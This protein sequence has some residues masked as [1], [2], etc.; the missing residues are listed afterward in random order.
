MNYASQLWQAMSMLID[1][2]MN[3]TL[4]CD[5]GEIAELTV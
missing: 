1:K 3:Q 4:S 2:R 5:M